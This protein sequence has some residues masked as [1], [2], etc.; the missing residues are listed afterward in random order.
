MEE[1]EEE[2]GVAGDEEGEIRAPRR[3]DADRS[4]SMRL[5]ETCICVAAG[6]AAPPLPLAFSRS[7]S[8]FLY[9][10]RDSG[11]FRAFNKVYSVISDPTRS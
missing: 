5:I 11:G 1:A 2:D 7:W 10:R 9:V 4:L 6:V 3:P 8:A